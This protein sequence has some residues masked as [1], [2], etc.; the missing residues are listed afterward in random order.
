MMENYKHRRNAIRLLHS[1]PL[2]EEVSYNRKVW[3]WFM[4]SES[5]VH[6]SAFTLV[7]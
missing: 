5:S 1:R 2:E 7:M 6:Q 3:V 4:L